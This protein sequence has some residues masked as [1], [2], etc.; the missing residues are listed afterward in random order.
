MTDYDKVVIDVQRALFEVLGDAADGEYEW[1]M[2][3]LAAEAA[4]DAMDRVVD[5]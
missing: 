2:F 1:N 4:I 3:R 5:S